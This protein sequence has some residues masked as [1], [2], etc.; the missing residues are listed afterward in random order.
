MTGEGR[1]I[2][3]VDDDHDFSESMAAYLR[4][5]G[6]RVVQ[7]FEGSAVRTMAMLERPAL[8]LMDVIME[9][10]TAGF[11]AVQELRQDPSFDGIPIFVV[12]SL[13]AAVPD[14]RIEPSR[15]WLGHDAFFAKPVDLDALMSAM[16]AFLAP[17][18]E[19]VA[20]LSEEE[21]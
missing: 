13:Y 21:S 4:A 20:Q 1:T 16:E 12:S 15:G 8:I 7:A 17:T 14:F 6:F 5:H 19:P 11:F 10:R 18:S 3:I 2:L 9:E